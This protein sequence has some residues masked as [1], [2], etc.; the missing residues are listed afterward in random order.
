MSQQRRKRLEALERRR[1]PEAPW[2]DPADIA[3]WIWECV[4]PIESGLAEWIPRPEPEFDEA[5]QQAFELRM[6]EADAM[7]ERLKAEWGV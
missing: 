5:A 4:Q 6:R 3:L 2:Q 7:H 1:R